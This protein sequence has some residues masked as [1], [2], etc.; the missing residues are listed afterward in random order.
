VVWAEQRVPSGL[1]ALLIAG[2][3]LWMTLIDWWRPGGRRPEVLTGVGLA[4]GMAG[5]ALL[6]GSTD[7]SGAVPAGT[8]E[9]AGAVALAVAS[10]GWSSGSIYSRHAPLPTSPIMATSVE[11]LFGGAFLLVLAAITGEFDGFQLAHVSAGSLLALV[12]LVVA[13]SVIG[14]TAYVWLLRVTTPARAS[15]YAYVNPVVAVILGWA[16]LGETITGRTMIAAAVIVT[17][18]AMI[19][20]TRKA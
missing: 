19:T 6:I 5:V 1:T 16:I 3:P 10:L 14:F 11:M 7:P 13:G 8:V 20:A 12:Y 18:V 2:T 15:T 17:A 4:V 9:P